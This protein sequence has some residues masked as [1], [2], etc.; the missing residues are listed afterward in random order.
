VKALLAAA[1]VAAAIG[2]IFALVHYGSGIARGARWLWVHTFGR[3]Q[4]WYQRLN[5]LSAGVQLKYF[6]QQLGLS[7][8]FR[9]EHSIHPLVTHTFV[10]RWFYVLALCDRVETVL[11]YAVTTRDSKFKPSIWPHKLHPRSNPRPRNPRLGF[12]YVESYNFGNPGNYQ[13]YLVGLNDAGASPK[14]A[15]NKLLKAMPNYH[16]SLGV[17]P[18][19]GVGGKNTFSSLDE[20]LDD[21]DVQEFRSSAAP[22]TYGIT[23]PHFGPGSEGFPRWLG[24]DYGLV[25]TLCE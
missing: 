18:E 12:G 8:V 4:A 5:R 2:S 23:A 22:N 6:T 9:Q 11:L 25:R 7:T 1:A 20:Y 21:A 19:L 17:F 24:V 14:E 10:H 16:V 13:T 3:R 15:L